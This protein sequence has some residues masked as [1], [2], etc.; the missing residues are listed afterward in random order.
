MLHEQQLN[1]QHTFDAFLVNRKNDFP[2]MA[3]KECVAKADLPPY[4]PF[5]VYG[6]S[7][8]GKS[9]LLG[10]MANVLH[11]EG[12]ALYFGGIAYFDRMALGP[13]TQAQLPEQCV[14]IDNAQCAASCR[15]TQGALAALI[16][17]FQV[18]GK[19]LA[20]SFDAHPGQ[21]A[22]LCQKLRS[23]LVSGLVVEIKR[24]D[25]DIRRQY[26]QR[27]NT[28][29]GL[30]LGQEQILAISHRYQDIRSIDGVLARIAAY[31]N[32]IAGQ[33]NDITDVAAPD[34]S[35][36]LDQEEDQA[37]VTPASII[38]TVAREFSLS[39]EEMTGKN[40]GKKLSLARHI[41]ML[42]CRELLGLSLVQTGRIFSGRDHSSVL[43]SIKKVKQLQESDKVMHKKVESLRQLCLTRH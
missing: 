14:F 35:A 34:I 6:Q 23:R 9:H 20:L 31:R 40:K 38:L 15:D 1:G 4:T 8:A 28:A 26:V 27:K 30:G 29:Q 36:I 37:F 16:D 25:L 32:L 12:K 19:L 17:M 42:L 18:S 33:G 2:F 41:A 13:G 39:P 5:V 10:A 24:P 21:Y 7:G 22:G 43:Y 11:K 3:A